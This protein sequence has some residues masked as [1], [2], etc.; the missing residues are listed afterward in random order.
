MAKYAVEINSKSK[1]TAGYR[2][3]DGNVYIPYIM[4][5]FLRIQAKT[6]MI[7]LPS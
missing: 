5:S 6:Y 1:T 3:T 7:L 4:M 2:I